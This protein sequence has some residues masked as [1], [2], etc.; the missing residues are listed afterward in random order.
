MLLGMVAFVL[1][2]TGC[3]RWMAPRRLAALG[4]PMLA[5]TLLAWTNPWHHLY[6]TAIT[7]DRI[8]EFWI[9]MPEYGPGFW[10]HFIY[11]YAVTAVATFLLARAVYRSS[12]VFRAQSSIMLFGML[13]AMGGEHHRHVAGL[14]LHPRG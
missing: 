9:A 13:A 5:L 12:G 7:N 3:D 10:A 8:G 14:R 2:Y 11:G 6:W 1:R 4:A